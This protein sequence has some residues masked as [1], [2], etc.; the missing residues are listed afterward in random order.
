[1][2]SGHLPKPA[3]RRQRRYRY[4]NPTSSQ[5]LNPNGQILLFA[6]EMPQW[7]WITTCNPMTPCSSPEQN[8]NASTFVVNPSF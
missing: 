4:A 8:S 1:M 3:S 2:L 5:D 6:Y 7:P